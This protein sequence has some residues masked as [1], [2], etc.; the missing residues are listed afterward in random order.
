MQDSSA[1][2][3]RVREAYD[4]KSAKHRETDK[5]ERWDYLASKML[6]DHYLAS[7]V[8][9]WGK[10]VL[11]IGC[12]PHPIDEIM[13]VRKVKEWVAS[14]INP[15]VINANQSL[16]AEELHP[17][18]FRRMRFE[19]ADA[20]ALKFADASF[21]VVFAMSS[22][23]HIPGERWKDAMKEISRVLKPG[24]HAV[25]T[26]SNK[27]NYAYYLWS[28]KVQRSG[29]A[30][31]GFEE[32]IYPWTMRSAL[33]DAGLEPKEFVSNFWFS[34]SIWAGVLAIPLLK[35]FGPRM[36]YLARKPNAP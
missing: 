23:E 8:D 34:P 27:L 9:L 12:A 20:T 18:I 22:L 13:Y 11:N 5:R 31:F 25:I 24:G 19:T 3:S 16:C 36:G 7:K 21:D 29:S 2:A 26:M 17:D 30:E 6:S 10:Q 32:C 14:D 4:V 35:W 28:K 33:V 1:Q 15:N